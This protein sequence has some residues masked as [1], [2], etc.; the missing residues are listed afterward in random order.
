MTNKLRDEAKNKAQEIVEY[1]IGDCACEE[2]KECDSC[3]MQRDIAEALLAFKGEDDRYLEQDRILQALLV[4]H[5]M[6]KKC[7]EEKIKKIAELEGRI[8]EY[9][10]QV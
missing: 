10:T 2:G 4:Q 7:C 3:G 1:Y 6:W 5:D 8:K 9:E